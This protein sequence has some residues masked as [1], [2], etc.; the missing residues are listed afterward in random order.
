MQPTE[1]P[2]VIK[3]SSIT[4]WS[5]LSR[6]FPG[7]ACYFKLRHHDW[8]VAYVRKDNAV[9]VLRIDDHDNYLRTW[10]N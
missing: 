6:Q 2:E 3:K 9:E 4:G 1:K 5:T 7:H 8:R 10:G